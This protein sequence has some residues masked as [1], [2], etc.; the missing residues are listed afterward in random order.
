MRNNLS[1]T[2]PDPVDKEGVQVSYHSFSKFLDLVSHISF[3][4]KGEKYNAAKGNNFQYTGKDKLGR[5]TFM[6]KD[7]TT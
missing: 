3:I 5:D 1:D 2:V 4:R 6:L 7:K